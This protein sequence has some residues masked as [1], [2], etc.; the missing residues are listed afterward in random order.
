MVGV[1]EFRVEQ[2]NMYF[3]GS[4]ASWQIPNPFPLS[5]F[6]LFSVYKGSQ[7]PLNK[8]ES[9]ILWIIE[10]IFPRI[11]FQRFGEE[12]WKFSGKVSAQILAP[13]GREAY[14]LVFRR[15]I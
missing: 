10:N 1:K 7:F 11:I 6:F 13:G 14:N 3:S 4:L 15:M 8:V 5:L 12:R 2:C 9:A